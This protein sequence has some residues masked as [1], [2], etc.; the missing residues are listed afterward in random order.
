MPAHK[1]HLLQ[2]ERNKSKELIPLYLHWRRPRPKP[3]RPNLHKQD[4]RHRRQQLHGT[5]RQTQPNH[6]G[7][8]NHQNQNHHH[9]QNNQR[10]SPVACTEQ[11][12]AG[13]HG[14]GEQRWV[15]EKLAI[16]N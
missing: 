12:V 10:Q 8:Q 16:L 9:Q 13:G 7:N 2:S 5:P 14:G 15:I 6:A 4:D 1:P 3:I 11:R